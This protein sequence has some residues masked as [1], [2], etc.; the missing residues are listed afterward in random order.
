MH[1]STDSFSGSRP[2]MKFL[3]MNPG[4]DIVTGGPAATTGFGGGGA[5]AGGGGSGAGG[6][7]GGGAAF[8][9]TSTSDACPARTITSRSSAKNPSFSN[10]KRYEPTASCSVA[11]P[12]A[13]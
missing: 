10:R 1:E 3:S 11:L 8:N 9:A 6:G 13:P 5:G 2:P 7:G 4:I 12:S